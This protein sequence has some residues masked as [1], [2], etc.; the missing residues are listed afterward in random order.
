[1]RGTRRCC[2]T[3]CLDLTCCTTLWLV[4]TFT[5]RWFC[6]PLLQNSLT[7]VETEGDKKVLYDAFLVITFTT[8]WFCIRQLQNSSEGNEKVLEDTLF[9]F[10]FHRQMVL[11]SS[12]AELAE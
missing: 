11:H 5:A 9:S 8:R 12:V 1:M 4:F 3:P 7:E 2:R 6:I 10:Y